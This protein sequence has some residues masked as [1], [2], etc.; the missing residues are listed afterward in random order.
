MIFNELNP[1]ILQYLKNARCAFASFIPIFKI[2]LSLLLFMYKK[3]D[4]SDFLHKIYD[5]EI[6]A[7]YFPSGICHS[8]R[9]G[10]VMLRINCFS[11]V[12][13]RNF[14]L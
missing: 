5:Y 3:E 2:F 10:S 14:I 9:S 12:I 8:L 7:Y 4:S 13:F 11:F 6:A 1:V